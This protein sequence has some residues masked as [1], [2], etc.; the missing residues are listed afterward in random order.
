MERVFS[1]AE[2]TEQYWLTSKA[3]KEG[4]SKM[5]RSDSEWAFQQFLQQQ[6]QEAANTSNAKPCSS[7]STST[8]TSSSNLDLKLKINNNN[9]NN[10]NINDSQDY[11]A[12]LKTKL[13]LACAAVA[14]SRGTLVKSQE[15]DNGSH[16][17]YASELGAS[18]NDSSKLL[19]KDGM[20]VGQKKPVVSIRS[21]TS[22]SSDDEEAEG[23]INMN[24]DMNPSDAKRVRRESAR[25]S[26]RRKQAHLSELETQVSQLR[27]EK[28]SL[29]KNLTDVTQKYNDSAVDNRILK[30]DVETLR[31]KVKMAEE[32]VKRFT[33][34]NPMFNEISELSSMGMG[35]SLF[36]GSP[37]E[38]SADAS[39]PEGSNNH[40][41]QPA[42]SNLMSSH[43]IRADNMQMNTA[44]GNKIGRT[45]SLPRV[46]SLEHLQN[47]IRG[48]A[49]EDK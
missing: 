4:E 1:I 30:A 40:F 29:L 38:S 9:N 31:A 23:E 13:D 34:L 6:E 10:N 44:A 48:G 18:G 20:K 27:G 32:T 46:A 42:S 11:Y 49:D 21:T 17:A 15:P 26:R 35:M 7:S 41:C 39:V 37:S 3:G 2:I 25:R 36:D 24:G 8:S 5:N 16:A 28:S 22:G 12:I 45:N 19:N 33:G 14:M 47:R 43:N